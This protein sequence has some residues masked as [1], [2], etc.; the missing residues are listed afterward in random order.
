MSK[1]SSVV[2]IK[3]ATLAL[4]LSSV[5]NVY[6]HGGG[7]NS[8][9]CHNNRKTGSYHCHRASK[10][11][12][13]TPLASSKAGY[14]RANFGFQSYKPATSIGFYT[15][16]PCDFVTIDHVVSLKDAY[17]SG[18]YYWA[19]SKKK[20]FANDRANHVPSCG[21]VNSSKGSARPSDFLHRSNDGKGLEY[22][23]IN[24]CEYIQKY[25]FVKKRYSLSFADNKSSQFKSCGIKL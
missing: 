12:V 3:Y 11:K 10:P 4:V 2:L 15:G 22:K 18:A 23:I 8:D 5:N 7:L 24:F 13:T 21:R 17:E 20:I 14:N 9:G 25:Y 19:D 1:R 16:Q 6:A